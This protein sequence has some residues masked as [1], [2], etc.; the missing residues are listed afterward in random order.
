MAAVAMPLEADEPAPDVFSTPQKNKPKMD[1]PAT[2]PLSPE[3]D[4]AG[5]PESSLAESVT[6]T[7]PT[8]KVKDQKVFVGAANVPA[9]GREYTPPVT[10][11]RS[12]AAAA[13]L[14]M[15]GPNSSEY[16][17]ELFAG[18][19]TDIE[20]GPQEFH[21]DRSD[22]KLF[23]E[24]PNVRFGLPPCVKITPR[25]LE[26]LP[27]IAE[28]S[29]LSHL[30]LGF[31]RFE[32]RRDEDGELLFADKVTF[33]PSRPNAGPKAYTAAEIEQGLAEH[34]AAL[35]TLDA[36]LHRRAVISAFAFSGR[37]GDRLRALREGAA[38]WAPFH[39]YIAEDVVPGP[40]SADFAALSAVVEP[41]ALLR[42]ARG[43]GKIGNARPLAD[44]FYADTTRCTA[45][46]AAT[47]AGDDMQTLMDKLAAVDE[48]IRAAKE[49]ALEKNVARRAELAEFLEQQKTE[50]PVPQEAVEDPEEDEQY[51]QQL[52]AWVAQEDSLIARAQA[53]ESGAM[54]A[55]AFPFAARLELAQHK[56]ALEAGRPEWGLESKPIDDIV[57]ANTAPF[58]YRSVVPADDAPTVSTA[59]ED[60]SSDVQVAKRDGRWR[61]SVEDQAKD[62]EA[63][64][65]L[66]D[67][68]PEEL[69]VT[70][71]GEEPLDHE[72]PEGGAWS[73]YEPMFEPLTEEDIEQIAHVF[74]RVDDGGMTFEKPN[75]E[76]L[77]Q[78][79][80]KRR[81]AKW[82]TYEQ[83][84]AWACTSPLSPL[85]EEELEFA[86]NGYL[87]SLCVEKY[88]G[89]PLN[90][91]LP[92]GPAAAG[93][94]WSV[95][96]SA[97]AMNVVTQDEC[98]EEQLATI[99]TRE[100]RGSKIDAQTAK[101]RSTLNQ[102]FHCDITEAFLTERLAPSEEDL[103]D[104]VAAHKAKREAERA[105]EAALPDTL[106]ES[107]L[108]AQIAPKEETLQAFFD[109]LQERSL[110]L[111]LKLMKPTKSYLA[112]LEL[113]MQEP[114]G[115]ARRRETKAL[116][117]LQSSI[118][119]TTVED[120]RYPSA[121]FF[122]TNWPLPDQ[123]AEDEAAAAAAKQ[124]A[125]E[126]AAV[127]ALSPAP[128]PAR[129]RHGCHFAWL[130]L[131][132]TSL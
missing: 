68:S 93:P 7:K 128:A 48:K 65:V 108:E 86:E 59:L 41:T 129:R 44:K 97:E 28:L 56:E 50:L 63:G 31:G 116:P 126:L 117:Q 8:A 91:E 90:L 107:V 39:A 9:R 16:L 67:V 36:K 27:L 76:E 57:D 124:A 101:R 14:S 103:P 114:I 60:D 78:S 72:L 42:A 80:P 102:R 83:D 29:P 79:L 6:D 84:V 64:T 132:Y 100:A 98:T 74:D 52:E 115:E 40:L 46:P 54:D 95:L 131:L 26:E 49:V 58:P 23:Y 53:R 55:V 92:S 15:F 45:K 111:K 33:D 25:Y 113:E 20:V 35:K 75:Q 5:G 4:D 38:F 61:M 122:R 69:R 123:S 110:G 2:P 66:Q 85:C 43:F 99:A 109:R 105:A 87:S 21:S 30:A 11:L 81:M 13:S 112:K 62:L 18:S 12:K 51:M 94:T 130:L 17:L 73:T 96:D 120:L 37:E 19:V 32:S 22:V 71:K 119:S 70:D 77:M 24:R 1:G 125:Q 106:V 104:I 127:R 34:T 10:P 3:F 118:G 89:E 47:E 82:A 121:A 88:E